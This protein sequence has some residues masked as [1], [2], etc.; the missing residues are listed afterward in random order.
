MRLLCVLS[1]KAAVLKYTAALGCKLTRDPRLAMTSK[2]QR[3]V[4]ENVNVAQRSR[5]SHFCVQ[6]TTY[7]KSAN[8]FPA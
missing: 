3:S 7:L 6:D 5:H 4:A 2:W 8:L 1:Y